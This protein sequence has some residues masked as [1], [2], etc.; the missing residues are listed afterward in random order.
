MNW[1]VHLTHAWLFSI[2]RINKQLIS[3]WLLYI[4]DFHQ[5]YSFVAHRFVVCLSSTFSR[6][7]SVFHSHRRQTSER[8][9]SIF[10]RFN[11]S[12]IN[13]CWILI[14]ST[15][16]LCYFFLR[17]CLSMIFARKNS[18]SISQVNRQL[19]GIQDEFVHCLLF[20]LTSD[21][22]NHLETGNRQ[23]NSLE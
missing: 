17:S 15:F 16:S 5:G 14:K 12:N 19:Y 11:K 9:K 20:V 4:I 3:H 7:P 23:E 10:S 6:C 8:L 21:K 13:Y 1:F 18:I 22:N 2:D